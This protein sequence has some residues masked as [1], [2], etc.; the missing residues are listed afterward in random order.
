M[1]K[2][3]TKQTKR[4]Q[5][6]LRERIVNNATHVHT[7][8]E[9]GDVSHQGDIIVV[10]LKSLPKSAKPAATKQVI[11]G[12][13]QGSRHVFTGAVYDCDPNEI[14]EAI[15]SLLKTEISPSYAARVIAGPG[16]LEHPEHGHQV[17]PDHA[18]SACIVQRSLD[19][20][21]RERRVQD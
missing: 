4:Q 21:E 18:A 19:S 10:C 1:T 15:R 7:S 13:T 8:W 17:F 9:P 16:T 5:K 2:I 20:E 14:V 6:A 11:D 3:L 12:S